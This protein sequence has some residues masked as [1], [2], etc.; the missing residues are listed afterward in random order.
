VSF[1]IAIKCSEADSEGGGGA[2]LGDG[3]DILQKLGL[4][5]RNLSL[6][7]DSLLGRRDI[8]WLRRFHKRAEVSES[9][10]L[11]MLDS[12]PDPCGLDFP[13]S[14]GGKRCARLKSHIPVPRVFSHFF[15]HNHESFVY[16]DTRYEYD[17]CLRMD[18]KNL[19]E[20]VKFRVCSR[21]FFGH[22][23]LDVFC[24]LMHLDSCVG[25]AGLLLKQTVSFALLSTFLSECLTDVG[26]HHSTITCTANEQGLR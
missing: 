8:T 26:R 5:F 17:E 25:I 2:C 22:C 13:F 1:H 4:W 7:F 6:L 10:M 23:R 24:A 3:F 21:L 16:F 14:D 20:I 19:K 15:Q 12:F 9:F 18:I 11:P